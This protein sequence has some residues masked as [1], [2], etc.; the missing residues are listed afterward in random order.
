MHT[1]HIKH[2]NLTILKKHTMNIDQTNLTNHTMNTN[3]TPPANVDSSCP[4]LAT[5][6]FTSD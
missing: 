3:H 2:I 4:S 5:G 1:L 6:A